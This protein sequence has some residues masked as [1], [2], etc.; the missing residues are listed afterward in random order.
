[1]FFTV[2][3]QLPTFAPAGSRVKF[4]RE[5]ST[6]PP[7]DIRQGWFGCGRIDHRRRPAHRLGRCLD[8]GCLRRWMPGRRSHVRPRHRRAARNRARWPGVR[9]LAA[10]ADWHG[11]RSIPGELRRQPPTAARGRRAN[12]AI[13]HI[14]SMASSC[15]NT[16]LVLG[17]YSQGATVIDIVAGVPL[18]SISLAVR[19][20]R[21][22]QT[23][24]QRS[25]SSAIRPTAPAD[26]CR[27]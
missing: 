12:D 13:S 24:S 3:P 20:L 10:P 27:A 6:H 16:K 14:K 18:G 22:T 4:R 19:Y 25:R 8:P 9:R 2:Y 15:P 26:R 5:Q 1:M 17:G 11:D 21:H 7:A 23:T